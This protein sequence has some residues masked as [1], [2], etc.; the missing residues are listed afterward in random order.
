[1]TKIPV[2]KTVADAYVFTFNNLG[3]IAGL[4]WIPML[5]FTVL[6][7]FAQSTY[8]DAMIAYQTTKNPADAWPGVMWLFVLVFAA[9]LANAMMIVPVLQQALGTRKGHALAHFALGQPEWRVFGSYLMLMAIV[10]AVVIVATVLNGLFFRGILTLDPGAATAPAVTALLSVIALVLIVG[11]AVVFARLGFFVPAVAVVEEKID[12]MRGW[13]LAHGNMLRI[14]AVVVLIALPV[15]V[16]YT[17]FQIAVFGWAATVSSNGQSSL[18]EM[19]AAHEH[20]PLTEAFGFFIAP[21]T[22]GLNAGAVASVYRTLVSGP[23]P[24]IPPQ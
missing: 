13:S 18:A 12:L 6:A 10:F 21:L 8:L 5:A 1:M 22:V 20:M 9:L 4:I 2:F 23:R 11:C 19:Q 3:V 14:I 15:V 16:L 7:F 17:A 24:A